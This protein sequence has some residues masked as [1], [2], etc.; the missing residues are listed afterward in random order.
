MF[1]VSDHLEVLKCSER[2]EQFVQTDSETAASRSEL[3]CR[4]AVIS[5][6]YKSVEYLMELHKEIERL[7]TEKL[8]LL[9]KAFLITMI[10]IIIKMFIC[11]D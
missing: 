1:L 4:T 8:I 10:M 9:R 2:R 11:I 3:S 7:R 5:S 6:D